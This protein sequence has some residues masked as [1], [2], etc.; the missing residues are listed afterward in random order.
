MLQGS[1]Y[2]AREA[3][4]RNGLEAALVTGIYLS[5]LCNYYL[6]QGCKH[7]EAL[8]RNVH[9][10]PPTPHFYAFPSTLT[11]SNGSQ[12]YSEAVLSQMAT[13]CA[14]AAAEQTDFC[15]FGMCSQCCMC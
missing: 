8:R 7:V 9:Q 5:T 1:L 11:S 12:A 15:T 3:Q 6:F 10:L 13:I 2:V 14:E 4:V